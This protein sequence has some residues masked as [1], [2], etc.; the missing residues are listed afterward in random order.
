MTLYVRQELKRNEIVDFL[1]RDFPNYKQSIR[2][3]DRRLRYFEIYYNND[4]TSIDAAREAVKKE[5]SG[6][7]KLLGYRALH[8]KIRQEHNLFVTRYAV[9]NLM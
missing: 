5:L 2:T 6:L 3:L 7:G 9:C 8:K 4:E 1:K